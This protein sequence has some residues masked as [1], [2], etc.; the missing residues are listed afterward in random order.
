M[1]GLIVLG[2]IAFG[3]LY[4][5]YM[6][7]ELIGSF[8]G[9]I[10]IV[11]LIIGVIILVYVMKDRASGPS[12]HPPMNSGTPPTRTDI[13]ETK[14]P[15]VTHKKASPRASGKPKDLSISAGAKT[16]D[17]NRY[18]WRS[19]I[20][21]VKI[22]D[23]VTTIEGSAFAFCENLVRVELP[24]SVTHIGNSAF[25]GCKK[26]EFVTFRTDSPAPT[27][28]TFENKERIIG[29]EA[30]SGCTMI[31]RIEI[32]DRVTSV[33]KSAF[34]GCANLTE[35]EL[36]K[37]LIAIGK[38]AFDGCRRLERIVIPKRTTYIGENAFRGCGNLT[39]FAEKPSKPD[40]WHDEWNPNGCPVDWN[41]KDDS[42]GFSKLAL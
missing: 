20:A 6:I 7:G 10:V 9:G 4:I 41:Y 24:K 31:K 26:L 17:F 40:T 11:L 22:P 36:P 29:K 38:E 8:A 25:Y 28:F 16:I 42:V 3:L 14:S 33:K 2:A 18:A 12:N 37:G 39:I 1:G 27:D 13:P 19:D 15:V 34:F 32:S 30:F 23:G 5:A 21:T 35:I